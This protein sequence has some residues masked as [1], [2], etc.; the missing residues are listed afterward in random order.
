M[1][2]H[3]AMHKRDHLS[4]RLSALGPPGQRADRDVRKQTIMTMRTLLLEH[5]LLSRLWPC[6]WDICTRH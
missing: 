4:E 3:D 2:R 6:S 1:D 5:F